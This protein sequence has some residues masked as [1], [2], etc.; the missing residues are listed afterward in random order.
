MEVDR[1]CALRQCIRGRGQGWGDP[2]LTWRSDLTA[3]FG[4]NSLWLWPVIGVVLGVG[5]RWG[6]ARQ[7]SRDILAVGVGLAVTAVMAMPAVVVQRL[8]QL[9]A[10]AEANKAHLSQDAVSLLIFGLIATVV[11]LVLCCAYERAW[12]ARARE[13]G[14]S[15]VWSFANMV[16][17]GLVFPMFI[18]VADIMIVVAAASVRL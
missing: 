11:L 4:Q 3:W 18:G 15:D 1:A 8:T 12:G 16:A 7:T 2:C 6:A 9:S 13:Q 5:A 17:F 14:I 10:A